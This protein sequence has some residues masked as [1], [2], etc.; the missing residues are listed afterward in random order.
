MLADT[1]RRN[2]ENMK[3]KAKT[4]GYA[5][6]LQNI[7]NTLVLT[8]GMTLPAFQVGDTVR[9]GMAV[10][11]IPDLEHWE[12]SAK[13][14]EL[15]RGRLAVGQPV[16]VSVVALAGKSYPGHVAILG[17]AT[18]SAWDRKFDCRVTLDQA[19]PELRPGMTSNFVITA[20]R[21]ENVLRVPSQ[22]IF[23]N[24]GRWLVY[25]KTST[26]FTPR[27]VTMVK[28]SESQVVITG[29]NEGDRVALSN[30]GEQQKPAAAG[31]SAMKALSK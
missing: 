23:E 15:D 27:E 22:A 5:S 13:V 11:Q 14:S 29:L 4:D 26:G 12:A 25:L 9:P 19:G 28:R 1:A 31:Q 18:G 8:T 17:N 3:L 16:S 7:V 24:D 6:P 2:I 30:P 20:E 21:L 10:V